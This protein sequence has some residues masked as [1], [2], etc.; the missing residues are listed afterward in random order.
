MNDFIFNNNGKDRDVVFSSRVRFARN[1][2][3]Y[4]FESIMDESTAEALNKKI[5]PL[6]PDNEYEIISFDKIK[7][8]ESLSYA[9]NRLISPEFAMKKGIHTLVLNK[10]RQ[11]SVM[12]NE[13]DHIR[14]QCIMSGYE[15]DKAYQ[16]ASD[17]EERLDGRLEFSFDEKLGYLTHC[18][19]NIGIAMRASVMLFLP[20]MTAAGRIESLGVYLNNIGLT[21][22]GMYGENSSPEACM[23]Q[24][25]NRVTLGVSEGEVIKLLRGAA[26]MIIKQE[27]SLRE[28]I[29]ETNGIRV[30]DRVMR[31]MGNMMYAGMMDSKE[32]L[33][34]YA[35]VRLG[36]A[37]GIINEIGYDA[38]DSLLAKAMPG[39][40]IKKYGQ[41]AEG[42]EKRDILRAA[43]IKE[44]LKCQ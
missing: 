20:A 21:L 43:L 2:S 5:L 35:D 1:I 7:P 30:N 32:F 12:I 15:L 28:R 34:S 24:V 25:S 16:N 14:L 37:L 17:E 22:R 31:S 33:T 6:F 41:E 11:I 29:K 26:D 19:T 27:R 13:E 38:I 9:E 36:I 40:L 10:R 23:Y 3:G 18:P 39:N 4:P 42:D 44:T 8:S